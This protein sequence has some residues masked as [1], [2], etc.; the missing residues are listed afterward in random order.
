MLLRQLEEVFCHPLTQDAF[1]CSENN[2]CAWQLQ[3]RQILDLLLQPT[4]YQSH[5]CQGELQYLSS[6]AVE[7]QLYCGEAIFSHL[8]M[9][10][11][12]SF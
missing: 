2:S 4:A 8:E 12:I 1:F 6:T 5:A 10:H 3:S 11:F 9:H 7:M